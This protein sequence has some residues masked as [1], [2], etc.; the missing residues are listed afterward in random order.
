VTLGASALLAATLLLIATAPADGN[1]VYW[2]NGQNPT[3]SVGRAKINGTGLNDN[4]I[5][6]LA[7]PSGVAVDSQHI[8][9]VETDAGRIGRA[10]L[11]GSG[12]ISN[13]HRRQQHGDLLRHRRPARRHRARRPE[14]SEPEQRV[15][16]PER[17]A[18]LRSGR[19]RQLRLLPRLQQQPHRA[20]ARR[21]R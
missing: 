8:Y 10:N 3:G 16:Q 15:H 18:D 14:W 17:A 12:V 5:P 1:F 2:T 20:C 4:F 19:E 6:N 11:D 21:W 9:W 7:G 13:L